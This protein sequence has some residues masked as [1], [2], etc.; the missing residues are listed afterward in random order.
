MPIRKHRWKFTPRL[1]SDAP[2][3]AG[4]YALWDGE[5]LICLGRAN[6][7][8]ETI[9][10]CLMKLLRGDHGREAW[11]ATHYSWEITRD[12]VARE[13]ELLREFSTDYSEAVL[14]SPVIDLRE[15]RRSA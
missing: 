13:R 2:T 12:P 7:T 8:S 6:G 1:V 9:Q 4:V 15:R 10:S 5:T 11:Q 3:T 14:G